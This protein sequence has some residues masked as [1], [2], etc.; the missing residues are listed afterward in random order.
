V[1][2][3]YLQSSADWFGVE[4]GESPRPTYLDMFTVSGQHLQTY[5]NSAAEQPLIPATWQEML[6]TYALPPALM[7]ARQVQRSLHPPDDSVLPW[8]QADV[9]LL[10]MPNLAIFAAIGAF[11]ATL[12]F[13]LARRIGLN[14]PAAW[15]WTILSF[16]FGP[17]GLLTFRWATD[18]P[19]RVRCPHCHCRRPVFAAACP[20]CHSPWEGV[21]LT[22]TEIF[23][24]ATQN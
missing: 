2:Q 18:W 14:L 20:C 19:A 6:A 23:G 7:T 12:T 4:T 11:C 16:A 21:P 13:F 9:A 10:P 5:Q 15:R 3:L 22:G 8:M 24:P 17:A 1:D